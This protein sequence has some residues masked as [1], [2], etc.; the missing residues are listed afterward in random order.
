MSTIASSFLYGNIGM[1]E[2]KKEGIFVM[3]GPPLSTSRCEV[4]AND[5]SFIAP[6]II[7][8][9]GLS[10]FL[11]ADA[12]YTKKLD[13]FVMT[14]YSA[15]TPFP[16][17]F[18]CAEKK[19]WQSRCYTEKIAGLSRVHNHNSIE[20][21][22]VIVRNKNG[23][24]RMFLFETGVDPS[25]GGHTWFLTPSG[26]GMESFTP[27]DIRPLPVPSEQVDNFFGPKF[28]GDDPL[29]LAITNAYPVLGGTAEFK[30][31]EIAPFAVYFHEKENTDKTNPTVLADSVQACLMSWNSLAMQGAS[32]V[33]AWELGVKAIKDNLC[34]SSVP[35]VIEPKVNEK[36]T[37]MFDLGG[38][39]LLL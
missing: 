10:T 7:N 19:K 1:R 21:I 35:V 11:S 24:S 33:T 28:L 12:R 34:P 18:L 4:S 20:Y 5:Y 29:F 38:I 6:S 23:A 14:C 37:P 31:G 26:I 17:V 9:A 8:N 2:E 3:T 13:N 32:A 30:E 16:G 25:L 39:D 15:Q 22:K 27:T 36:W